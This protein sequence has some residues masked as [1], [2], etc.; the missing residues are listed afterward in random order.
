MNVPIPQSVLA[1]GNSQS[2]ALPAEWKVISVQDA[3]EVLGGRQRSPSAQGE[4]TPYLRVANVF[5]GYIDTSDVL[6]MPFTAEERT[7][8]GLR[9]GD[10]LLNEGQSLE[11]VGRSAIYQNEPPNCCFQNTLVRFRAGNGTDPR[12]AQYLFESYLRRGEFAKIALQTTSIAHL[13]AGRFAQM[14]FVAPPHEEQIAIGKAMADADALIDSLEEMLT[15]KRHI[16]Q[17]AM[18]ELLTGKRR[19]PGFN[20]EWKPTSLSEVAV[21]FKG[22]GLSKAALSGDG[23]IPCIHY[24]QLFTEYGPVIN[25]VKSFINELDSGLMSLSNDVLMPT[26]DVTPTGLA[27]AS[28]VLQEGVA[29]GGDILVIRSHPDLLYGPFLSNVIRSMPQKV[30]ELV[31]GSTVFHIYARDM[32]G[33]QL[34]LPDVEEQEAIVQILS[35]MDTDIAALEARLTKAR[36]FKRAIAQA[37]L[38]GHI[39]LT[40]SNA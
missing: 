39:R 23:L 27:K 19:L 28:C 4:M 18:Q 17:G 24:G 7:R 13:G 9:A 2:S 40:E 8:F 34:D 20:G 35:D 25:A 29:L 10:I 21:F 3:G 12:Y 16:K 22:K 32:A 14:A 37:L 30:L 5:A 36:A 26:S 31:T 38:T 6:Q 1:P 33:Y 15:K 11:L